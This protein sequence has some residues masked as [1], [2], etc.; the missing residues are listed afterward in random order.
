MSE[1]GDR[2]R[3]LIADGEESAR[4]ALADAVQGDPGLELVGATAAAD[5]A[6]RIAVE[7][8]PDVAVLDWQIPG[9]G[10]ATREITAR[11]PAIRVIAL[12]V[13][14]TLDAS[15]DMLHAGAVGLMARGSS[16]RK[17]IETLHSVVD[18]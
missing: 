17:L 2:I 5:E 10:E 16:E 3:V 13:A 4:R 14:D 12:T 9:G 6:I 8:N 15:Y 1:D 11:C 18:W 7:T